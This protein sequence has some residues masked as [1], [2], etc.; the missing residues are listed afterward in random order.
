MGAGDTPQRP[1]QRLA[2]IKVPEKIVFL[3]S[4]PKSITGKIQR[5]AL[6]EMP[7][8][9]WLKSLDLPGLQ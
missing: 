8:G 9:W 4:L 3:K 5:P 7:R 6:K 1:V 2:D